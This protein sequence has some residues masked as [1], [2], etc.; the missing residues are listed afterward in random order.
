M[1]SQDII[2][3]SLRKLGVLAESEVPSIG[4]SNDAL[5]AA[6]MLW[7]RWSADRLQIPLLIQTTQALTPNK[8]TYQIGLGA[9]ADISITRP[10]F[11]DHI[12]WLNGNFSPP[13]EYQMQPLTDDGWARLA[14][15]TIT[16]PY[17]GS[18]WYQ[19]FLGAQNGQLSLWPIPTNTGLSMVIYSQSAEAPFAALTTTLLIP[20]GYQQMIIENLAVELSSEYGVQPTQALAK[21]ADDSMYSVKRMNLKQLDMAVDP[22]AQVQGYPNRTS[23]WIWSGP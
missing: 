16:N 17:P 8:Q 15:K 14:I 23:W 19:A 12:N 22:G 5:F 20:P 4:Q 11:I 3:A 6:N 21:A 7:D 18:W 13:L 2:N 9:G 1:T 10:V